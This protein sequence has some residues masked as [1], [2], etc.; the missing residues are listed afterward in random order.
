MQRWLRWVVFVV[1]WALAAGIV[2]RHYREQ[3]FDVDEGLLGETAERVMHGELPHRDFA[4]VYTGGLAAIDAVGFRVWGVSA[5]SMRIVAAIAAIL[6]IPVM[7][8]VAERVVAGLG[9]WGPWAA[10]LATVTAVYWSVPMHPRGM[11][12]WY[13]LYLA[14]VG[15]WAVL[16]YV[17]TRHRR[18]LVAAGVAAGLSCAIKIVGLYFIAAVLLFLLFDEQEMDRPIPGAPRTVRWDTVLIDGAL[19]VFVLAVAGMVRREGAIGFVN[20]VLPVAAVAGLLAWRERGGAAPAVR[21]ER[22]VVQRILPFAVGLVI[23]IAMLSVP[24]VWTGSVGALVHGVFVAPTLRFAKLWTPPPPAL[25]VLAAVPVLAALGLFPGRWPVKVAA[26][27]VA[28]GILAGLGLI[29]PSNDPELHTTAHVVS[30]LARFA[31]RGLMPLVVVAGAVL[32]ARRR[33]V[34]DPRVVMLMVCVLATGTLVQFPYAHDQYT[35]FVAPLVVLA[36]LA[37]A[38]R[39]MAAVVAGV[40]VVLAMARFRV[41][42][43]WAMTPLDIPRG[44]PLVSPD[45]NAMYRVFVDTVRAHANGTYIFCSPDCPQ[46]YFLTG[47]KNPTRTIYELFDDTTAHT[48]RTLQAI[49][50]HAVREVVFYGRTETASGGLDSTLARAL[51]AR[52]PESTRVGPYEVRWR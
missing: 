22:L 43:A 21:I 41:T 27:V 8:L 18:W 34:I 16:R 6:W 17:D 12:T 32:L 9:R 31:E 50:A 33:T 38:P 37:L 25:T 23:P 5:E 15:A 49:D 47:Y 26:S 4:D 19:V 42:D 51:V 45:I 20:F 2:L 39:R 52:Y 13:T 28:I 30:G 29:I 14:T 10:A 1:T 35:A 24:Y 7:F 46:V 3:F 40:F 11:P 48:A 36:A 44:G